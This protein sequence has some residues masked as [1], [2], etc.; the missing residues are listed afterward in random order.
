M[1]NKHAI[2]LS[3]RGDIFRNVGDESDI[4]VR[5]TALC[6]PEYDFPQA[7]IFNDKASKTGDRISYLPIYLLSF[8]KPTPLPEKM[9]FEI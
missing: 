2:L 4:L 7:L 5:L 6:D 8:L 1:T 3:T 9:I